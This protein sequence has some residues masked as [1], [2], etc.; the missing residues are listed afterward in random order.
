[1]VDQLRL[2]WNRPLS[3]GDRARLF[4]IAVAVIAAAAGVFAL[5]DRAIPAP[6]P[7]AARH[8]V[9]PAADAPAAPVVPVPTAEARA[10]SEEGQPTAARDASPAQIA[11]AKRTTRTFL[12]AYLPFTYGREATLRAVSPA[13]RQRLTAHPPRVPPREHSRHP[14]VVTVQSDGVSRDHAE[15]AALVDDGQRRYT[16]VLELT[17]HGRHWLVTGLGS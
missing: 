8:P 2:F 11:A 1:L 3:D 16:I 13:L 4:A 9:I 5:L 7:P 12:A 6:A 17:R 14:R 10:P 15:I